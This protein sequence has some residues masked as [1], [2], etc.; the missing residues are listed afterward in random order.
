MSVLFHGCRLQLSIIAP[1]LPFACGLVIMV[2][3]QDQAAEGSA[4]GWEAAALI[5]AAA[6]SLIL[7]LVIMGAGNRNWM[8]RLRDAT[9]FAAAWLAVQFVAIFALALIS[10]A[11]YGDGP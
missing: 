6:I 2:A 9:L 7:S 3:G 5:Y 4:P 11:L 10:V 1:I 8:L